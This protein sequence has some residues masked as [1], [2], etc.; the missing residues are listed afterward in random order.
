MGNKLARK[1]VAIL[2]A[3]LFA[4]AMIVVRQASAFATEPPEG[5]LGYQIAELVM[6]VGIEIEAPVAGTSSANAPQVT[7]TGTGIDTSK[8]RASWSKFVGYSTDTSSFTFE[9]G[10]TYY[11]VVS[12]YP[13]DD[14]DF[15]LGDAIPGLD[16]NGSDYLYGGTVTASGGEVTGKPSV[17]TSTRCLTVW[18]AVTPEPSSTVSLTIHWSSVDG[19]DLMDPVV[20]N[21]EP[22]TTVEEAIASIGE[23]YETYVP[24][25]KDGYV[26]N[27]GAFFPKTLNAYIAEGK[28]PVGMI[29]VY[30]LESVEGTEVINENMDVYS[31]MYKGL[32]S[33]ISASIEAPVCGVATAT[34]QD[35]EDGEWDWDSQ[36]NPPVV[37]AKGEHYAL[38]GGE[39]SLPAYWVTDNTGQTPFVGTFAGGESY[40][41]EIWLLTD[42]GYYFD[43]NAVTVAGA[44]AV[45]EQEF[46]GASL[47]LVVKVTATHNWGEWAVTKPATNGNDGVE[48]RTCAG[49]GKQETRATSKQGP[50]DNKQDNKDN[51]DNKDNQANDQNKNAGAP[52][53]S[54]AVPATGD[55]TNVALCIALAC[56]SALAISVAALLSRR[57]ENGK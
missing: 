38:D 29:W 46:E 13:E 24:F 5:T 45:V 2:G 21:V 41:A 8:T 12:L 18:L 23:E 22:G 50:I 7:I 53:G 43:Q 57:F 39:D 52:N 1:A 6:S 11:A 28:T 40:L 26:Q 10:S 32:S 37:A 34:P 47:R 9:E 31:L 44:D 30:L 17:R 51:K 20:I 19:E 56:A 54:N 42:V 14:Y 4:L 36:T 25:E 35:A 3:M 48:T 16:I 15:K 33:A 49:C 55:A 27:W